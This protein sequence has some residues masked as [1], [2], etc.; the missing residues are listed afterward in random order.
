MA[1]GLK[2]ALPGLPGLLLALLL[3]AMA[4]A[5][6]ADLADPTRP[7]AGFDEQAKNAP[8]PPPPRVQS[9][10]LMGDKPYA[11]VDG[12]VLRLGDRLED[13][14]VNR[15]DASGV[16]LRTPSGNK[17]L[18]LLPDVAKTPAGKGKMEKP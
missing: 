7:P 4:P 11:I 13:G 15:I 8:P 16:W 5:H 9:L 3:A 18:K 12:R 2:P 1:D 6:A 10:F 14:R 17:Q